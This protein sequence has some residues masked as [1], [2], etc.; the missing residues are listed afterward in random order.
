M[1]KS[2]FSSNGLITSYQHAYKGH[3]ASIAS[4]QMTDNSVKSMDDKRLVGAVMLDF[5]AAFDVTDHCL[6]LNSNVMVLNSLLCP[7]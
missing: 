7:G 4:S 2:Y 5:S 1:F 3:S 6:L